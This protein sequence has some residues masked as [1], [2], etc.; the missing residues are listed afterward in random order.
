M[1][2]TVIVCGFNSVCRVSRTIEHL[3]AQVVRRGTEWDLIFVDNNSSD[4]SGEFVKALW[5]ELEAP[6]PLNVLYERKAGLANARRSGVAAA[7]GNIVVFCDDDNWLAPNYIDRTVSLFESLPTIGAIGGRSEAALFN[8]NPPIWF[9]DAASGYAVGKQALFSQDVTRRGYLWGA[10]LAV[11]SHL[12][13]RIYASD[14]QLQLVGREGIN[15]GSGDDSE[16][17][18]LIVASGFGLYYDQDLQLQH[19][20]SSERLTEEYWASQ[21][22]G[23]QRA[24]FA[25]SAYTFWI[26]ALARPVSASAVIAS[27]FNVARSFLAALRYRL[28]TSSDGLRILA[29]TKNNVVIMNRL[30]T[31]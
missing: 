13:S 9:S 22:S 24:E 15:L 7:R 8:I 2:V 6:V 17:C 26:H 11:R 21:I 4:R 14:V 28:L 27:A 23:F 10:G 16:I 18:K 31:S 1:S 3:A 5:S 25:L 19:Y 12:L 29:A 20:I 30:K